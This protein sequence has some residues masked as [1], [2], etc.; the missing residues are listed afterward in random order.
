MP[1]YNISGEIVN[2]PYNVSGNELNACYELDGTPIIERLLTVMTFNPLGWLQINSQPTFLTSLITQYNPDIAGIQEAGWS[3]SWPSSSRPFT[4]E[5][6][7][8]YRS[9]NMSNPNGLLSKI[10]LSNVEEIDFLYED[11]EHWTYQ[12]CNFTFNGRTIAWYNVHLTWRGDAESQEGRRLQTAQLLA[13]ANQE[14]YVIITGDFNV[15]GHS[16]NTADYVN[17]YKQFA[18]AGYK[19]VN[20]DTS[21]HCIATWG[22]A[23]A[24]T[25]LADLTDGCD[26]IIVSSN[27][28]IVDTYFDD[29]KLNYLDGNAIDHIPVVA[30]LRVN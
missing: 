25:S 19:M 21:D 10:A 15:W 4:D 20:F 24:P 28:D 13:D 27:I 11:S 22:D 23:T 3:S 30:T 18:D 8:K 5:F 2:T 14:D 29:T 12:K 26:N 7:Y 17:V 6:N 16:Y 9:E 1:I